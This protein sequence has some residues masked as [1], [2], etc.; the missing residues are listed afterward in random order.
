MGRLFLSEPGR[1]LQQISGSFPDQREVKGSAQNVCLR[2][3]QIS[4]AL[5][6]ELLELFVPALETMASEAASLGLE[7]NWQK[8][9]VQAFGSR[10]DVPPSVTVLGQ[11]VAMVEEFVYLG[12]LVHSSTQSSPDIS[13]R[14]AIT[15]AAM[16]NLDKQIWRSRITIPTKL[17]LYNTCILLTFLHG[18]ECWAVTKRDV[19][20][21]DA[22]DQWCLR[23]L[24]GI[25]WY[26]RVRN[27]ELRRTTGQPRLSAIVQAWRLSLFGYI[28]RM[29]DETDARSII[30]ASPSEDWRK[31][32]GRPR[33]TWMKTIQQDLRS[34]NLSLDEA[35]T[36]AQNSPLWRLMSAF[37]AT[38]P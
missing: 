32:P 17:K 26:H 33:T 24:L 27:D 8:T 14:D 38:H 21:I 15:R 37:G 30:T 9:K 20:K 10:E 13:R 18:S 23:K 36:V 34:N 22:L 31:P 2:Q 19:L 28:S 6:V 1:Q 3:G 25:K 5:L 35:I 11:E 12:S 16:Q 29:P 7:L 4:S